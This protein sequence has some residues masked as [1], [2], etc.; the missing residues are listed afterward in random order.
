MKKQ[1][2]IIALVILSSPLLAQGNPAQSSFGGLQA[3]SSAFQSTGS[4]IMATGSTYSSSVYE[5]GS[6][7]PSTPAHVGPRR[8][9]GDFSGIG[10]G[11]ETSETF[12]NPNYGPVGDALL[13][14]LIMALAFI[15]VIALRRRKK[16]SSSL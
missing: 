1:I 5:V 8:S 14:L 6:T 3:P 7:A 11:T 9:Y 12:N 15:A 13:P 2:F 10:T 16:I 4:A